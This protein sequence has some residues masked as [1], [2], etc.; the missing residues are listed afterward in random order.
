MSFLTGSMNQPQLI[1]S[2][3]KLIGQVRMLGQYHVVGD[4]FPSRP[5]TYNVGEDGLHPVLRTSDIHVIA[6]GEWGRLSPAIRPIRLNAFRILTARERAAGC[7]SIRNQFSPREQLKKHNGFE[8]SDSML[9]TDRRKA[10]SGQFLQECNGI[11]DL[12]RVS[13]R[14]LA[15]KC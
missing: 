4:R 8:N 3:P 7:V 13:G 12:L 1:E 10:L 2:D 14:P 9:L 5:A 6:L 11:L 15:F